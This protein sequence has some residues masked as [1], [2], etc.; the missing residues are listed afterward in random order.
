MK[1]CKNCVYFCTDEKWAYDKENHTLCGHYC[2]KNMVK[3]K[4]IRDFIYGEKPTRRENAESCFLKNKDGKC[5]D[6]KRKWWKFWVE[7]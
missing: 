7:R 2:M 6:Y 3:R 1:L 4:Y 5:S